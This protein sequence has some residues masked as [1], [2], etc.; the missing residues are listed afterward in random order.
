MLLRIAVEDISGRL[1]KA[2]QLSSLL[3]SCCLLSEQDAESRGMDIDRGVV[4]HRIGFFTQKSY[5]LDLVEAL[6]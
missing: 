2:Q 5:I 1:S 6:A 4:G 3:A